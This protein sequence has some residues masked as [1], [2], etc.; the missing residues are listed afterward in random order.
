[1]WPFKKKVPPSLEVSPMVAAALIVSA[2]AVALAA[3]ALRWSWLLLDEQL[4]IRKDFMD[5]RNEQVQTGQQ[6]E[7]WLGK[8]QAERAE[9]QKMNAPQ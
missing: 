5:L 6:Y 9:S 2:F 1:M 3:G 8:L 4:R 7:Y